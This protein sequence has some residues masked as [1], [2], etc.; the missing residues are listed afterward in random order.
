VSSTPLSTFTG[1]SNTCDPQ[2][3]FD[4]GAGRWFYAAIDCSDVAANFRLLLGWSKTS[5]PS[6][7]PAPLRMTA[8]RAM[9]LS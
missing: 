4:K 5:D 8:T 9:A 7:T 2:V 3:Q 6:N 1:R